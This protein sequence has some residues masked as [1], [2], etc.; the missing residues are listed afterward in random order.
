MSDDG[1]FMLVYNTDARFSIYSF[2]S[3]K[4]IYNYA[5]EIVTGELPV[6]FA[7]SP[8]GK[9]VVMGL[10]RGEKL[11]IILFDQSYARK[12]IIKTYDIDIANLNVKFA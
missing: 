4:V 6:G 3:N 9:T 10:K 7:L 2:L 8:D 11:D 1:M 12:K 5:H